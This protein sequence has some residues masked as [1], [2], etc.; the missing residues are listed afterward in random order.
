MN[1]VNNSSSFTKEEHWNIE[2][3]CGGITKSEYELIRHQKDRKR[4][5]SLLVC[6]I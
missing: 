6:L 4:K 2:L 3:K 1:G 5:N